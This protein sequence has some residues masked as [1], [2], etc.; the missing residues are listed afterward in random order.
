MEVGDKKLI[1]QRASL[2]PNKLGGGSMVSQS[3]GSTS[4]LPAGMWSGQISMEPTRILCLLNMVVEE[5]LEDDE[6]YEGAFLSTTIFLLFDWRLI[7]LFFD[8]CVDILG[9]IKEECSKYGRIER[10][11]IPRPEKGRKLQESARFVHTNSH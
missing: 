3:A 9:D 7:L 8:K 4:F 2:G 6:E 5:E 11:A 10:I 1:V